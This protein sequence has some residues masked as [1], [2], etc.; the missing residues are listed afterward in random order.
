MC[1]FTAQVDYK[2]EDDTLG[3]IRITDFKL[4]IRNRSDAKGCNSNV[5]FAPGGLLEWFL[6]IRAA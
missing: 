2:A 3:R 4:Q 6:M 1:T 5:S